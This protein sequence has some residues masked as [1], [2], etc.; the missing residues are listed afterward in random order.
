MVSTVIVFI[1]TERYLTAQS[2]QRLATGWTVR[3]SNAGGSEIVRT[4][5]DRPWG[6]PTLLQKGY[7]SIPG[8]KATGGV[9]LTA[10]PHLAPR[11]QEQ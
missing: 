1:R 11:S 8:G 7:P 9:P 5:P 3:G 10:N 2:V 4:P 6:P